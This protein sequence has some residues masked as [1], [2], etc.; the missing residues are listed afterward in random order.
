MG[1]EGE[2][3]ERN[4]DVQEI[5]QPVDLAGNPGMCN[6]SAGRPALNPLS[7]ASQAIRANLDIRNNKK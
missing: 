6:L 7:H 3:K 1:R 2:G 5:H 4:I